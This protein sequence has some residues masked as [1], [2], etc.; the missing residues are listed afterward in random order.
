VPP[1]ADGRRGEGRVVSL[2]PPAA[3]R[4]PGKMMDRGQMTALFGR[5]PTSPTDRPLI[6]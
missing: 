5:R 4:T 2:P 3:A 6:D 1:T